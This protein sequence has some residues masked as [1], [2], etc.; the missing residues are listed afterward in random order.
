LVLISY[1]S[2]MD[3]GDIGDILNVIVIYG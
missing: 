3:T 2:P 1:V